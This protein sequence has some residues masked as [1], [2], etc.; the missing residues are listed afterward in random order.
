MAD[1]TLGRAAPDSERAAAQL[2]PVDEV[3]LLYVRDGKFDA[4]IAVRT[5]MT[6]SETKGR[7]E[8][9]RRRLA[10]RDRAALASWEPGDTGFSLEERSVTDSALEVRGL[11]SG[12][13]PT[14]GKPGSG[15]HTHLSFGAGVVLGA[16]AGVLVM[17]FLRGAP[18]GTAS[19]VAEMQAP[20]S[21]S[22]RQQIQ[23]PALA[24]PAYSSGY[25]ASEPPILAI[26]GPAIG[27]RL[28][29]GLPAADANPLEPI[30]N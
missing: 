25:T 17:L 20:P 11:N 27:A 22:A 21:V 5:G 10:V 15:A 13:E 23:T 1:S 19:R 16:A 24:T 26:V 29:A 28:A 4:E 3:I 9:I 7:I 8:A 14:A 2:S 18:S 12:D 30:G 6:V